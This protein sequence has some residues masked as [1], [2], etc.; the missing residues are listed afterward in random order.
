MG[1][2]KPDIRKVIYFGC[3]KSLEAYYQDSGR[4]GRDGLP[5][6]CWLYYSRRDFT[7]S[8]FYIAGATTVRMPNYLS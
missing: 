6:E 8:E 5:S 2:D 4:A 3:P 1:I 7:K